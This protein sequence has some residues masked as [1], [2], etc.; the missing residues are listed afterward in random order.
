MKTDDWFGFAHSDGDGRS[1][2][3]GIMRSDI[4]DGGP[5]IVYAE[6]ATSANRRR[7]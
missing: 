7:R 1:F 4:C 5:G 2:S 6:Y 3:G